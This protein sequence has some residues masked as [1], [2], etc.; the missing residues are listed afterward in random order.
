MKPPATVCAM[1]KLA[2]SI[3]SR[4]YVPPAAF[5]KSTVYPERQEEVAGVVRAPVGK[6]AGELQVVVV[7]PVLGARRHRH[8]EVVVLVRHRLDTREEPLDVPRPVRGALE[9]VTLEVGAL[10]L[11]RPPDDPVRLDQRGPLRLG[12]GAL[13]VLSNGGDL[14]GFEVDCA[15]PP[16]TTPGCDGSR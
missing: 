10:L 6:R 16:P 11:P 3:V 7:V 12:V 14:A 15:Q 5:L 8:A 9:Q 1:S 13:D 2:D 4:I